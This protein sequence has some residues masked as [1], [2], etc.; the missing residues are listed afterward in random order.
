MDQIL[1]KHGIE[2]C[3]LIETHLRSGDILRLANY[4]CH[5]NYRLTEGGVIAILISRGIYYHAVPVK[6]LVPGATAIQVFLAKQ[7]P[8]KILAVYLSPSRSLTASDMS[9]CCGGTLPVL[10]AGDQNGKNVEWNS[11]LITNRSRLLRYYGSNTHINVP[12]KLSAK[13]DVLDVAITKEIASPVY[14]FTF[15][16][17]S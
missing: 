1:E 2:V 6:V 16:A 8:F 4:V 13:P 3:P 5:R 17:L 7:K 14:L 10:M 15:S 9:A 12:F 11:G